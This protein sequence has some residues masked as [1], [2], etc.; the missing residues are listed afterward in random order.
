MVMKDDYATLGDGQYKDGS[1]IAHGTMAYTGG[2]GI[3][4][5]K[6]ISLFCNILGGTDYDFDEE[7][8]EEYF[9]YAMEAYLPLLYKGKVMSMV[10]G[11]G[12]A[13][14]HYGR[15]TDYRC[16]GSRKHHQSGLSGWQ[17]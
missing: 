12:L 5:I 13:H 14:S 9:N 3:E 15:E 2:Y 1:Y 6:G 7:T 4:A 10:T 17:D 11:R 8:L 16:F